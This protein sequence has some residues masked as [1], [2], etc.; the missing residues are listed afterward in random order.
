[1]H[2]HPRVVLYWLYMLSLSHAP[3]TP[4]FRPVS[5]AKL[6]GIVLRYKCWPTI[7][8]HYYS[9]RWR[10]IVSEL[11]GVISPSCSR[12][13]PLMSMVLHTKFVLHGGLLWK[14]YYFI[15]YQLLQKIVNFWSN[16]IN[17]KHCEKTLVFM[18][19]DVG[20]KLKFNFLLVIYLFICPFQVCVWL[21]LYWF[22]LD[23]NGSTL[24]KN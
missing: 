19:V 13:I 12:D 6:R 14:L 5:A 15:T 23:Y 17:K 10:W 24:K 8:S 18:F 2:V 7:F 3:I 1:M 4:T 16:K 21:W 11:T 20:N 22:P 9:R